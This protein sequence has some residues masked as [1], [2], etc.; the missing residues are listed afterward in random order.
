MLDIVSDII[1]QN[2]LHYNHCFKLMFKAYFGIFCYYK[3]FIDLQFF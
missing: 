1:M 2:S 3:L